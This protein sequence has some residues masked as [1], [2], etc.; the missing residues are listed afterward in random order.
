MASVLVGGYIPS[1]VGIIHWVWAAAVGSQVA[2]YLDFAGLTDAVG[3]V[4][5]H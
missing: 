2:A 4:S 1:G 5:A 3:A